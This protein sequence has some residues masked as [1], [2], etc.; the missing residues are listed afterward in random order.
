[1]R[2]CSLQQAGDN[3]ANIAAMT[4]KSLI[5]AS[6]QDTEITSLIKKDVDRTL[7]ELRLFQSSLLSQNMQQILYIWAKEN[8]EYKYQQGM[9][10]ILATVLVCLLSDTLL[11]E[12]PAHF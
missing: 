2:R 11:R 6:K 1:M 4:G 9:N 8:P 7:P 5:E 12:L 3:Q 10:D